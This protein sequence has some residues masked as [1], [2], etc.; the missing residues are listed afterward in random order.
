MDNNKHDNSFELFSRRHSTRD[1]PATSGVRNDEN[2][3]R[4]S[5]SSGVDAVNAT[6]LGRNGDD[7]SQYNS[8]S[9]SII[10]GGRSAATPNPAGKTKPKRKRSMAGNDATDRSDTSTKVNRLKGR[11]ALTSSFLRRKRVEYAGI[12]YFFYITPQ[13]SDLNCH[14]LLSERY[15]LLPNIPHISLYRL[16]D[17]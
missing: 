5:L 12:F 13:S 6:R 16:S 17:C 10:S 2:R 4:Y 7:V 3:K 9:I 11:N 15:H 14:K 1:V 8:S